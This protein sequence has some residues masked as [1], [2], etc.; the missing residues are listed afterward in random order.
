[1]LQAKLVDRIRH[2]DQFQGARYEL[3][4]AA[5]F[6]RAGFRLELEDESDQN[7]RHPEFLAVHPRTGEAIAVE[8]KSR[9]RPGVLGRL[10]E[11][12]D[13]AEIKAGIRRLVQHALDKGTEMPYVVC[14]DLNLPPFE[15]N[16]LEQPQ[17]RE[18]MDTIIQK[19]K[20]YPKEAF[21]IT[22]VVA[23]NFPHHYASKGA[24]DPR[25]D[26]VVSP[27]TY[28]KHPIATPGVVEALFKSLSEYSYVPNYFLDHN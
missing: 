12:E 23:T 16:L 2:V 25:R 26:F 27:S 19:E 11:R 6:I 17:V 28:P 18:M 4:I 24:D 22:V 7:R 20:L 8:A 10:G 9:H 14:I 15:H 1:L 21:P 13:P 3:T 5:T